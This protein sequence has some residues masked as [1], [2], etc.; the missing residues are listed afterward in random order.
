MILF[1]GMVRLSNLLSMMWEDTTFGQKCTCRGGNSKT[2][3]NLTKRENS[4]SDFI[5]F[6]AWFNDYLCNNEPEESQ[7]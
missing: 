3:L 1:S 2:V 5:T 6:W 7:Q 4:L